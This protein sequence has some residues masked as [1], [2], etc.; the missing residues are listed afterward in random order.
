MIYRSKRIITFLL[1]GILIFY[2]TTRNTIFLPSHYVASALSYVTY[3]IIV[4]QSYCF[5]PFNRL[6]TCFKSK[7]DLINA[8]KDLQR[9]NSDL[10]SQL[11]EYE[12]VKNFI[13]QTKELSQFKYRYNLSLIHI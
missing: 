4:F 1:V 8:V 13:E 7:K 9:R 6:K 12:S 10:E 2:S 5:S 11:I 3:P